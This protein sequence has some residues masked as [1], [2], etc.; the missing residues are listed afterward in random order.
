[1]ADGS[2]ADWLDGAEERAGDPP[3]QEPGAPATEPEPDPWRPDAERADR[4]ERSQRL[5]R[6][7]GMVWG[8]LVLAG[9]L[10]LLAGR[11]P[12][13]STA[14]P[15]EHDPVEE[16]AADPGAA[17]SPADLPSGDGARSPDA[18]GIAPPP[19]EDDRRVAAAAALAVRLA[20]TADDEPARYVDQAQ[21][22]SIERHG[23]VAVVTVAAVVL[24]GREDRWESVRTARYAV[25]V[26]DRPDEDPVVLGSPW[27]LA[28]P[29]TAEPIAGEAEPLDD[30]AL[31]TELSAA[32]E[33]A[34]YRDLADLA[35]LPGAPAPLLRLQV[36]ALAPGEAAPGRHEVWVTTGDA[37]RVAG[38]LP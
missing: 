1:M 13:A 21:P 6:I 33:A 28:P 23:E 37:P 38:S 24:E 20:L 2:I 9:G 12:D 14:A 3:E 11:L 18:G 26:E 25:A 7:A 30:P 8:A 17:A 32:L 10:L 29:R 19:G 35:S 16:V 4:A 31:A 34:G 27:P 36:H 22:E 15:V 5:W